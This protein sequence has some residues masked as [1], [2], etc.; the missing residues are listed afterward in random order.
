M[1]F[2]NIKSWLMC[3]VFLSIYMTFSVLR[4]LW[5]SFLSCPDFWKK[6]FCEAPI[7]ESELRCL[8]WARMTLKKKIIKLCKLW[9]NCPQTSVFICIDCQHDSFVSLFSFLPHL[10]FYPG[11]QLSSFALNYGSNYSLLHNLRTAGRAGYVVI[12]PQ[13]RGKGYST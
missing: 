3:L 4:S 10:G 12:E 13:D 2:P 1:A 11:N 9:N 6:D 7:T 5:T 8:V